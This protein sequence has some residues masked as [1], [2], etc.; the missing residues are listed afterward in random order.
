MRALTFQV[1]AMKITSKTNTDGKAPP[2]AGYVTLLNAL[3]MKP[4]LCELA[5]AFSCADPN[6][7]SD[8][9]SVR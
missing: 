6:E 1:A 7:R 4:A 3:V 8:H 5:D 2:N 9:I